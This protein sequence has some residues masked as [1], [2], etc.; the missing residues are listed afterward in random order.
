METY[1]RMNLHPIRVRLLLQ[2]FAMPNDVFF[3][4]NRRSGVPEK[5]KSLELV[6]KSHNF[7]E[8]EK[9]VSFQ[10]C[11]SPSLVP[12]LCHMNSM[13]L[14]FRSVVILSFHLHRGLS[15]GSLTSGSQSETLYAFVISPCMLHSPLMLSSFIS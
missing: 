6:K 8:T 1:T 11:R 2:A 12:V 4:L 14:P 5:L 10:V 7:Y 9:F 3:T 15:S 13:S